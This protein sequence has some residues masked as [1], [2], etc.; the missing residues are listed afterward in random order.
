MVS[1]HFLFFT[2]MLSEKF[3]YHSRKSRREAFFT[4]TDGCYIEKKL[5]YYRKALYNRGYGKKF[6]EAKVWN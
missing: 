6:L 2:R 4:G 5:A 3:C 1:D